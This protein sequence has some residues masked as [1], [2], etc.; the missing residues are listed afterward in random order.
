MPSPSMS[1]RKGGGVAYQMNVERLAAGVHVHRRSQI[2]GRRGHGRQA[3]D[4]KHRE[5][6]SHG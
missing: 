6:R 5:S 1:P 4:R 3:E 2:S